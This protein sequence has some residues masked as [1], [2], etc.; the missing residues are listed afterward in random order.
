[1]K[2]KGSKAAAN[3]PFCSS[4]S[5]KKLNKRNI[6]VTILEFGLYFS[7]FRNGLWGIPQNAVLQG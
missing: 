3:T 1:M 6:R 4:A 5:W 2:G 7:L